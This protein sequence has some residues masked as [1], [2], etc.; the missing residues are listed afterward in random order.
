MITLNDFCNYMLPKL[1]TRLSNFIE[2]IKNQHLATYLDSQNEFLFHYKNHKNLPELCKTILNNFSCKVLSKRSLDKIFEDC[3]ETDITDENCIIAFMNLSGDKTILTLIKHILFNNNDIADLF[4]NYLIH[5][6]NIV[7][8]AI[9]NIDAQPYIEQKT[10]EW[11]AVRENMFSA[12]TIGNLFPKDCGFPITKERQ[13]IKERG[14]LCE[15]S[16]FCG[17]IN[18]ATRHGQQFEDI[19]GDMYDLMN[20][21]VSKEYGI[22]SDDKFKHIG[23]SPDGIIIDLKERDFF[24]S[25]KMGRMREIKNPV[26][27]VINDVIPRYYYYQMQQQ[28]YVAKL[29]FC[30]F[31]QTDFKYAENST[32]ED[33]IND[34]LT[35]EDLLSFNNWEGM[36][37]NIM[38]YI[39]DNL[40]YNVLRI[41]YGDLLLNE[42][43]ENLKACLFNLLVEN[44]DKISYYPL[45][46]LTSNGKLKGIAWSFSRYNT[47][48]DVDFHMEW[49]PLNVPY[50]K[51][52]DNIDE[53]I[54]KLKA[55]YID[56]GYILEY[57]QYWYCNKYKVIEVEYNQV[58]YEDKVLP[59]L[60]K[61]WE[62]IE[63]MRKKETYKEKEKLYLKHYPETN[64]DIKKRV[65]K[66]KLIYDAAD[67]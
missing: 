59:E 36:K 26:S 22:L 9:N 17:W 53:Y 12:S 19:T 5:M 58:L 35:K 11:F 25:L 24:T 45:C 20:N 4:N 41:E 18:N 31:I 29:P 39:L 28:L 67:F 65:K 2:L 48:T 1:K 21:L 47:S 50:D 30:D 66:E 49:L 43:L 56:D 37:N 42:P 63:N 40:N 64:N 52:Y 16:S 7:E 3:L 27:R 46:N 13:Q 38:P 15:K 32:L 14:G 55:K 54:E 57:T 60:H 51:Y 10:P 61:K 62:L 23:A 34:V 6:N 44:W 8:T 33:L